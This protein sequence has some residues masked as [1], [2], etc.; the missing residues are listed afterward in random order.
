MKLNNNSD[1]T[2]NSILS[3]HKEYLLVGLILLLAFIIRMGILLHTVDFHGISNGR[4][5]EAQMILNDPLN[6]KLW[7]P[8]HPPG[9]ILFV[10]I[11]IKL[12]GSFFAISRIISLGFGMMTILISYL[13]L[14]Q[15]FNKQIALFSI[16]AIS[17]YS[18]H[19]VYSIIGTS[20]TMFHFF[21]FL[22]LYLYEQ[23]KRKSNLSL[24]YLFGLSVGFASMCRY[25]G[26]LLIPFYLF[27]LR[28]SKINIMGFI[29]F[30]LLFPLAWMLVN[31]L[32]FGSPI[33]FLA[34]NN[35]IVPQQ[36]NW[37]RDNGF[38]I[39]FIYK[40][41]FWPKAMISTLGIAVFV[42]G[43]LGL[44]YAQLNRQAN[45]LGGLFIVLFAIFV[46][47]TLREM[48]Y[49]QPRYGITLGLMLIPF[50]VYCFMKVIEKID[51]RIPR[52]TVLILLWTM[53]IPIG[54]QVLGSSLFAPEFAKNTAF[55]LKENRN[56]GSNIMIDHCGD[57][58]FREPIKVLSRIDPIYFSLMPVMI[59]E[60]NDYVI[61]QEKFF[62]MIENNNIETLVYSPYG[63]L[64]GIL[65]L[66]I[67]NIPQQ[68]RNF[69]FTLKHK[70]AP[71]YIY[72][73]KKVKNDK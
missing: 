42:F 22:S 52:W 11:G 19:I 45:V 18:A 33:E 47:N 40:F 73:I 61:D 3:K 69:L 15:V 54:S 34:S 5:L 8:V 28:K 65:K 6:L 32:A 38:N 9:H 70:N 60:N 59:D 7:V 44:I 68:R 48:L 31:Y 66:N 12:F 49:L 2:L 10:I 36:I 64:A 17:L 46:I 4:I 67:E 16:L 63:D 71:Y 58:K 27:F 72:D 13:Y 53:I 30:A 20:E 51:S 55:Y 56:L 43:W 1:Q 62:K 26:L 24:L 41:L 37:I 23:F 50:S 57:E 25:E 21:L 35:F 29:S 39:D 14:K